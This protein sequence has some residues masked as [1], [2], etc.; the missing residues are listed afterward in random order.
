[1]RAR[2]NL[3]WQAEKLVLGGKRMVGKIHR[4]YKVIRES[5]LMLRK[6]ERP[7]LWQVWAAT[8]YSVP[9]SFLFAQMMKW[10]I[11]R[12]KQDPAR[13]FMCSHILPV[14]R[15]GFASAVQQ[16]NSLPE[17]SPDWPEEGLSSSLK[18]S[19]QAAGICQ[20]G[21]YLAKQRDPCL[22]SST[23]ENKGKQ[24][25]CCQSCPLLM[26]LRMPDR[27]LKP[28][29]WAVLRNYS[30]NDTST[31]RNNVARCLTFHHTHTHACTRVRVHLECL[32]GTVGPTRIKLDGIPKLGMCSM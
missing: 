32:N 3:K 10:P 8:L 9:Y 24:G 5:L 13:V 28:G 18:T 4:I 14:S 15:W 23:V 21:C 11:M 25:C 27:H 7:F 29:L 30:R 16:G 26:S 1:M 22:P 19:R 2:Q 20:D 6:R 31:H 17:T 12:K